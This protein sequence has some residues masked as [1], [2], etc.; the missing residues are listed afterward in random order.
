MAVGPRS[1]SEARAGTALWD[2]GGSS[3]ANPHLVTGRLG[4]AGALIWVN[5]CGR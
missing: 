5:L 3:V 2:Y 1:V 4:L